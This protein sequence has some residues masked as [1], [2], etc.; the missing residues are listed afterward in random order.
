LD[1]TDEEAALLLNE[2]DHLIDGDRYFLFAPHP[3]PEGHPGEDPAGAGARAGACGARV[4]AAA[5]EGG[6]A[7]MRVMRS[8]PGRR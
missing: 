3:Y 4:C 6:A 1:L 5:R 2:L 8:E 7:P